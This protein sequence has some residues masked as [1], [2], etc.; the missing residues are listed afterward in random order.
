M[1]RLLNDVGT[2]TLFNQSRE[3]DKFLHRTWAFKI[4]VYR[5]NRQLAKQL[6][7]S[8]NLVEGKR[9]R[10]RLRG[11]AKR[12]ETSESRACILPT[13]S[14]D[15]SYST[16]MAARATRYHFAVEKVNFLR[17]RNALKCLGILCRSRHSECLVELE[18]GGQWVCWNEFTLYKKKSF[19]RHVL[20]IVNCFWEP[21]ALFFYVFQRPMRFS[22]GKMARLA[23]GAVVAKVRIRIPCHFCIVSIFRDVFA[24]YFS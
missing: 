13:L 14:V 18:V 7:P 23:D 4:I 16:K 2:K 19:F 6:G 8:P 1:T 20:H 3:F 15:H 10:T 24:G 17:L 22:T 9:T 21:Y 5:R 12:G 11:H